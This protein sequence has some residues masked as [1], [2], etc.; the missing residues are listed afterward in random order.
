MFLSSFTTNYLILLFLG[1]LPERAESLVD[2]GRACK[3]VRASEVDLPVA[4]QNV[5][6]SGV[7][8]NRNLVDSYSNSCK[9]Q[10][11]FT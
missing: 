1:L 3:V 4:V 2:E 5:V 7:S 6:I 8:E 10:L 9:F 11:C